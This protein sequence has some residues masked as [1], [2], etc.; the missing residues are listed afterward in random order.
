MQFTSMG[1]LEWLS[2]KTGKAPPSPSPSR[3]SGIA[4]SSFASFSSKLLIALCVKA[5]TRTRISRSSRAQAT[6]S[7]AIVAARK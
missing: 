3:E 2:L 6:S 4:L 1:P 7:R 5:V